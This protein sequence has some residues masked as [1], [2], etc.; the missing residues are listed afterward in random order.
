MPRLTRILVAVTAAGG[1][2]LFG[3]MTA[4]AASASTGPGTTG[5]GSWSFYQGTGTN[6]IQQGAT[7]T[8]YQAQVQQPINADGSSV[9]N[10]KSATIPLQFTVQQDTVTTPSVYPDMLTS[11]NSIAYG[12]V[13]VNPAGTFPVGQI[14]DLTA[15]FT[16]L[17]GHNY[18]GALRWQIDTPQ[19]NIFVYYG[20]QSQSVTDTGGSGTNQADTT[21]TVGR[22]DASQFGGPYSETWAQLMASPVASDQVNRIALI[23]DGYASCGGATQQVQLSNTVAPAITVGIGTETDTYTPGTVG[24]ASDTGWVNTNTPPMW[25]SLYLSSSSTPIAGIDESIISTQGDT[26]GQYRQV[27]GKYMYNFPVNNLPDSTASYNVGIS[28]TKDGASV[29]ITNATNP[30]DLAHFGLK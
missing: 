10:H 7:S 30:T 13:G 8:K 6:A 22:V 24:T 2:T 25:V 26:G 9:F 20:D 5:P 17:D 4:G 11:N 12:N 18:C 29:P 14:S 21:D 16:W 15:N 19:G 28:P 1:L 3:L 23:L 27:D